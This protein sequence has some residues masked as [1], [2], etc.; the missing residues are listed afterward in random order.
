MWYWLCWVK[1]EQMGVGRGCDKPGP[2]DSWDRREVAR[3]SPPEMG[4]L[5]MGKPSRV[6]VFSLS[7]DLS[8]TS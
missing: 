2:L 7:V 5:D 6:S 1:Q 3:L 4:E 8:K